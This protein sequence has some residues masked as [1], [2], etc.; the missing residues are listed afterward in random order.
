MK[1]SAF[2]LGRVATIGVFAISI[3]ALAQDMQLKFDAASIKRNSSTDTSFPLGGCHGTDTKEIPTGGLAA[4]VGVNFPGP[5]GLGRCNFNNTPLKD[6]IAIAYGLEITKRD[7]RI[8]SGP[9]WILSDKYR[10]DAIAPNPAS[11]TEGELKLMLQSML[12]NRFKLQIHKETRP[13]QDTRC[14]FPAR[15]QSLKLAPARVRSR[16]C[17]AGPARLFRSICQSRPSPVLFQ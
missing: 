17:P 16:E 4:F 6:L 15:V 12:V 14:L 1:K 5:S 10:I 11:A 13:L 7:E 3:G 9:D 2:A 8:L